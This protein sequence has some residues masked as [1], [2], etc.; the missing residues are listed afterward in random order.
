M[1][2]ILL[3]LLASLT[4]FSAKAQAVQTNWVTLT[5]S[6]NCSPSVGGYTLQ[7]GVNTNAPVVT[8][9]V[10]SYINDCGVPIPAVTNVYRASYTNAIFLSGRDVSVATISNLVVGQ[11]YYFAISSVSTSGQLGFLSSE[12]SYT[13]PLST[14]VPAPPTGLRVK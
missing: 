9:V 12:I 2:Q 7:Y 11:P 10:A 1:K 14:T 5:W 8:N 3:A 4:V 6:T 13:I